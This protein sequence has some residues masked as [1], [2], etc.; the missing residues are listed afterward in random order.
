MIRHIGVVVALATVG[1]M[2]VLAF[3]P[4]N[5]WF[6]S[7]LVPAVLIYAWR[8][9]GPSTC[10]WRGYA[11]GLGFFG[12][13]V[14][15]VF[16]SIYEFGQAP[17][18]F[19][20]ILTVVFVAVMAF[21][22]AL[23]GWVQARFFSSVQFSYRAVLIIPAL[24]VLAE[25]VRSWI[26]TGFPWLLLGHTQL[27][28]ILAG[29]L[30]VGGVL[31]V[32]WVV[33]LLAASLASFSAEAR[34]FSLSATVISLFLIFVGWGLQ[35][36][37]W[38]RPVGKP[39]SVAL[40]QG[41]I[42][43]QNKWS[44]AWLNPTVDRYVGLT[45][46]HLSRDLIIWPEVALPGTY[47]LFNPSV[48]E[49]LRAELREHQVDLMTG[50]LY[51]DGDKLFNSLVKIGSD[52]EFYHKRH[53]VAFGEYIPF[54][55]WVSWFEKWI[56]LPNDDVSA[57][58]DPVLLHAHGQTIASS[59]CYEDAFGPEMSLMLPEA[60]LLVNVSNDAW[61]GDSFAPDQHLQIARVRAAEFGRPLL[62]ATN[63]GVS[64]IVDHHGK[65]VELAPQFQIHVLTGVA[66][67][68]QG[69][70]PYARFENYPVLVLLALL[71][72]LGRFIAWDSRNNSATSH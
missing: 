61:F 70:T 71:L 52:T 23:V 24:W 66:Q 40:I 60:T 27:D 46:K 44:R 56:V 62:R 4:F 69:A 32:S 65:L 50:I 63:T 37:E 59:I 58:S 7:F 33:M 45:Q 39:L 18:P 47:Q 43:Q 25:W 26:F 12:L 2:L 41:N 53:L 9:R 29:F 35:S 6:L 48:L 34:R 28:T 3:A 64:A 11:F 57:G 20:I 21:F 54:R 49:P 1:A 10:F 72:L 19:A 13:G 16:N 55:R 14:S 42:E 68:R 38:T 8:S 30:P 5:A 51:E 22:P 17:L 31:F 15:W 36:V 67:G